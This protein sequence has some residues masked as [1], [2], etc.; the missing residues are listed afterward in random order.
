LKNPRY[1][2]FAW[3]RISYKLGDG[4]DATDDYI[5]VVNLTSKYNRKQNSSS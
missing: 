2:V 4:S 5:A 3:K 1:I